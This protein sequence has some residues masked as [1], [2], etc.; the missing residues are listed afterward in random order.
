M[1]ILVQEKLKSYWR[2]EDQEFG[3][4]FK[5]IDEYIL[6]SGSI[7]QFFH[8][9]QKELDSKFADLLDKCPS[10]LLPFKELWYYYFT[11][12]YTY[13]EDKLKYWKNF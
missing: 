7:Y 9:F 2:D 11:E 8:D 3:K 1:Y 12:Y 4:W 6:I 13:R 10:L 5:S